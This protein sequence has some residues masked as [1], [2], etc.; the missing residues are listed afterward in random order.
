MD[1]KNSRLKRTIKESS[2]FDN[3]IPEELESELDHFDAVNLHPTS[4]FK[5]RNI[6]V[7]DFVYK[8]LLDEHKP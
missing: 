8:Q 3:K 4:P 5:A 1:G 7:L 6:V 2:Q